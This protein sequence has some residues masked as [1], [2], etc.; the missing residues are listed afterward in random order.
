MKTENAKQLRQKDISSIRDKILIEDQDG[1][2]YI[3]KRVPKR[4][5]LDHHHQKRIKGTGLVRGVLDSNMNVFLAKIENNASR[6]AIKAEDLPEILR[7]VADYLEKDQ[8]PYIHP[9]EAPKA[10]KLKKSSYNRLKKIYDL[11]RKFPEFPKSGKLTKGLTKIY[12]IYGI[13]PEFYK[14]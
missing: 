8:Y 12:E 11:K 14:T 13:E 1:V 3:C 4:P 5:T 10:P 2:C 6:Y 9:S 7:N